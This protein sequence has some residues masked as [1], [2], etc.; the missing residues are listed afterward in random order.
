MNTA[1]FHLNILLPMAKGYAAEHPVGNNQQ[2]VSEAEAFASLPISQASSLRDI[3]EIITGSYGFP[4]DSILSEKLITALTPLLARQ[5]D[6]AKVRV[7]L[8]MPTPDDPFA[9]EDCEVTDIGH[10]D[11][12]LTVK[13]HDKRSD[14][15]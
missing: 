2:I 10:A 7:Q 12:I 14:G 1:L 4:S 6:L 13:A 3:I 8:L 15:R 11:L 5:I 9:R